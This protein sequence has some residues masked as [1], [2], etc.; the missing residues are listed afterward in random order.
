[1]NFLKR[2]TISILR[3]LSKSIILLL[4]VFILGTVIAGAISVQGAINNTSANL[5]RQ[6]RPIVSIELD[7]WQTI[8][9]EMMDWTEEARRD[10]W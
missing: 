7:D 9:E 4:L 3:R 1:M 10:Y 8:A 6:M 5:R 2:A